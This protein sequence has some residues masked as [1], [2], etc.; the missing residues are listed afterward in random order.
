M[1]SLQIA[2]RDIVKIKNVE[3]NV[4]V[5]FFDFTSRKN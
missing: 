3:K 4:D 5:H 1:A 2:A